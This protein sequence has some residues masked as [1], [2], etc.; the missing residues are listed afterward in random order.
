MCIRD[1]DTLFVHLYMGS[2][3]TKKVGDKDANVAITSELP[4]DGNV[5]IAVEAKDT[6]FVLALRIPDWCG[7]NYTVDGIEKDEMSEKDGYLYVKKAW[8]EKDVLKLHFSMPLLLMEADEKV[9]EDAGKVAVL[10]GPIVYCLEEVDNGKE[11]HLLEVNPDG[12][13]EI[14]DSEICGNP[15]KVVEMDGFRVVDTAKKDGELYHV[16]KR[17]EKEAVE[18]KFVPYYTWAN[19]GENEMEVWIRI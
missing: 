1:R 6:D 12:K 5:E 3:L 10:R 19:R 9:R 13:Y 14:K 4:W 18:L 11:L 17:K 7:G 15:V 2:E 16:Y 8:S